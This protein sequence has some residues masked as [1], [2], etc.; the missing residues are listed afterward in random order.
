M[1]WAT[2]AWLRWTYAP[3][4]GAF[5]EGSAAAPPPGRR[6]TRSNSRWGDFCRHPTQVRSGSMATG[7][8]FAACFWWAA[9]PQ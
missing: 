4:P 1:A 2:H 7:Y 8:A 3:R 9:M 6:T 5:P